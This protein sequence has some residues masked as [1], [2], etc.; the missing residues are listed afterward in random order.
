MFAIERIRSL[1]CTDHPYQI[2]LGFNSQDYT[3][4]ALGIMQGKPITVTMQFNPVTAAWVRD[5]IWHP[6]QQLT[7]L[8]NGRLEMV[9]TVAE[10][11]ELVGWILGFGGG[12]QVL[13]PE[14]LK[15]AVREEAQKV[16]NP[17]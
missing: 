11:R 1:T 16:L 12:V 6:S 15:H 7:S 5:R 2:P 10:N 14:S 17:G 8:K 9:L 3:Q 13:Q 4:H